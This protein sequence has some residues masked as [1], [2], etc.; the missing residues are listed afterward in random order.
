MSAVPSPG[1]L[2]A[3]VDV[4]GTKILGVAV[5]P[6]EPTTVVAEVRVATPGGRTA[7]LDAVAGVV[8][9]L[10]R[11]VDVGAVGVGIAGLVDRQGVLRVGPHLPG[12]L[13][14][15]IGDEID[16]R[17]G[18]PVRVDNDATCAAWG[19]HVAGASRGARDVLLVTL[20]TGIG[21]GVIAD[22][23]LVRG[24]H[25]FGGEVG[26]MVVDPGG[27]ACPCGRHGCWERLASGSG[28]A[29]LARRAVADG[30]FP[31]GLEL[32][33]GVDRLRGEHVTRA[34]AEG[35]ADAGAIVDRFARWVAV[36]LGN[37]LSVLDSS[38]VV[39]GGGLVEVGDLL[40]EPVRAALADDLMAPGA[41]N[42][43]RVV[44]ATLGERAGAIGAAL[45]GWR[46]AGS[47]ERGPGGGGRR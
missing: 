33:G 41:R 6:A 8:R 46:E 21:G 30:R 4:G 2:V 7:V 11:E 14:V 24:A 25:G 37:L 40:L 35:D 10:E 44:A 5:D 15:P 20:G 27:P 12:L 16:A 17:V 47:S 32:A 3:G 13:D 42:D 31:R 43:V 19:E 26:H 22:G 1:G 39:V 34:A 28:L 23:E 45:L 9:A 29:L 36:G 38:L 18:L